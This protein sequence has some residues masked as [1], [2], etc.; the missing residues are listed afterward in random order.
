MKSLRLGAPLVFLFLSL[1]ACGG[2]DAP[3]GPGPAAPPPP[4]PPPPP[5]S[6]PAVS[7]TFNTN[8]VQAILVTSTQDLTTFRVEATVSF[9]E[10]AGTGGRITQLTGVIIKTPGGNETGTLEVEIPISPSGT[11]SFS[12]SQ[13]FGLSE[14]ATVKWQISASGLDDLG[15]TFQSAVGEADVAPPPAEPSPVGPGQNRLEVWGGPNYEQFLGCFTCSQFDSESIHNQFGPYGSRFSSTSVWNHFSQYGSPFS[16]DSACNEFAA[17]PPIV[18]D[19]ET[20]LFVELTVNTLRPN[21][22]K[23]PV[24]VAW[25]RAV[26]CEL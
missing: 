17:N 12:V 14:A 26:V 1:S 8:P 7:V 16:T 22:W 6:L 18:V 4:P 25:L 3:T 2:G 11:A 13:E 19:V 9:A 15:R 24:V 21:A 10:T 20:Q 23:D 5:A